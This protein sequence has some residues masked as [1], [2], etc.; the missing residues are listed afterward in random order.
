MNDTIDAICNM[1]D[2]TFDDRNTM[3]NDDTLTLIDVA[4]TTFARTNDDDN[5]E[6][7]DMYIA[8]M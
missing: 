1:I 8:C 6:Q 4:T 3:F 5:D 2:R 7:N